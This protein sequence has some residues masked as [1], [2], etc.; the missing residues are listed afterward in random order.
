MVLLTGAG[1]LARSFA[2]LERVSPGFEPAG[3][4]TFE[5]TMTGRK[6][7]D[8]AAL[9]SGYRRLFESLDRLPGVTLSGAVTSLPFS[10]FFAWGPITVE[11]RVPPAG[12]NFLNADVRV[13]TG[14]Y[15]ESLRIPLLRGRLFD[16]QDTA[17]KPRVALVDDYM[18]Q[19]L[20][21]GQDAVGKRIRRGD[22]ASN[23]PWTTVVGVV[24]RVKQYALD[25]DS[26]IALYVPQTQVPARAMYVVLRSATDPSA[27]AAA[28]KREIRDIDPDLPVYHVRTM[29][30]LVDES[31]AH[32]RFSTLLLGLFA[33][34]ALV[35]ATIGIYGVM[36][37]L[38]TQGTREIGIRLALGATGSRVLRLVVGR[39]LAIALAGVAAGLAGAL[40]L[41]RF[42][43]TLLFG[44]PPTD[45][46]TFTAMALLLTTV[47]VLASLI[48]ARRA[49]RIDP[50]AS[51]R[52]E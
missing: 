36:A 15:F 14:R 24:G 47:A 34:L 2:R 26:R 39:G 31:L 13:V 42:L 21:P 43:R 35:L 45:A 33:A 23:P 6:Y 32:R 46:A 40:A 25:A 7:A 29:Q 41:T 18:A 9:L 19:Q 16:P 3:A 37:Y 8:P 51:L 48:P 50:M 4:L 11:G 30:Q 52:S 49:A 44:V 17:D 20:W 1:L 27:P 5:L 12:E 22:P 10:Q 38:V 28:V